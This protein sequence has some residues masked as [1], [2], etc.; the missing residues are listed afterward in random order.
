M[1]SKGK[2]AEGVNDPV[3]LGDM[4]SHNAMYYSLSKMWPKM[5]IVS[6]EHPAEAPNTDD[7]KPI[8]LN[9]ED[10]EAQ[11][12]KKFYNTKKLLFSNRNE[13]FNIFVK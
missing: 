3:T 1:K 4:L 7:I 8:D 5:R 12:G 2:T 6:E 11:L 10:I 13:L 9:T